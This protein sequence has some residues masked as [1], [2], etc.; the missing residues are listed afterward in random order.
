MPWDTSQDGDTDTHTGVASTQHFL[1]DLAD[2]L[3]RLDPDTT[4][5][6]TWEAAIG[7]ALCET[8]L[9]S[10]QEKPRSGLVALR[11]AMELD[12]LARQID[13]SGSTAEY[14]G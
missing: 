6:T 11:L 8:L 10:M 13:G 1:D 7:R 3:V 2:A 9:P 12:A 4:G 14:R 5:D